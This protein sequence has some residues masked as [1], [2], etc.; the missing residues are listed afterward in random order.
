MTMVQKLA[1]NTTKIA[2]ITSL[3]IARFSPFVSAKYCGY[4]TT[5]AF[6]RQAFPAATISPLS[7]NKPS[8]SVFY[9]E[10]TESQTY[11]SKCCIK[12]A[13]KIPPHPAL[14]PGIGGEGKGEGENRSE[15]EIHRR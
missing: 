15:D 8:P 7:A 4:F 14:S 1:I 9:P 13:A 3:R 5:G 11:K 6:F 2:L 10:N 12:S